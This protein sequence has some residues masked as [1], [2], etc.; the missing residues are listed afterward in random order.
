MHEIFLLAGLTGAKAN[1]QKDKTQ[2]PAQP[3]TCQVFSKKK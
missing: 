2:Q 3:Q 1:P